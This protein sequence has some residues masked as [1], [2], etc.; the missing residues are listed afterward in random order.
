[1]F[2]LPRLK[3]KN[4]RKFV[5]H[6]LPTNNRFLQPT[7]G[8]SFSQSPRLRL[9][10]DAAF[11]ICL[12]NSPLNLICA[13]NAKLWNHEA[14][15]Q[16]VT[17]F[18]LHVNVKQVCVLCLEKGDCL[19]LNGWDWYKRE[20]QM[21]SKVTLGLHFNKW[22]LKIKFSLPLFDQH[23]ILLHKVTKVTFSPSSVDSV[24]IQ[25]KSVNRNE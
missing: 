1:M 25:L 3:K 20:V 15:H 19:K 6:S 24:K 17:G 10:V 7:W 9:N 13:I 4:D 11:L 2:F 5:Y 12:G 21:H 8:V 18:G 14:T 23:E 16:S 22:S